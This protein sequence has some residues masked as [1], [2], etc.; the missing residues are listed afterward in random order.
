M[1]SILMGLWNWFAGLFRR[2]RE[3]GGIEDVTGK[4]PFDPGEY[5]CY[6]GCPNSKKAVKLQLGRKAVR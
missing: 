5:I 6:Y 1:W 3:I 4:D 2:D